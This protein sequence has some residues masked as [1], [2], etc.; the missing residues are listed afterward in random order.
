M[1]KPNSTKVSVVVNFFNLRREA[2]RTLFSLTTIYQ[3]HV[4]KN[5]YEV[6]VIDNGSTEP[7]DKKWVRGMGDHFHYIYFRSRTL[8]PAGPSTM[9]LA[10]A[11]TIM[12]WFVLT[13]PVFYHRG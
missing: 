4:N 8:H 6:I 1:K 11:G 9:L 10:K 2:K 5:D 12:L 7:L 3:L 13:V